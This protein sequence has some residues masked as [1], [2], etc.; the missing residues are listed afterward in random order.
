MKPIQFLPASAARGVRWVL[1]DVDDTLT[2][3]GVL[4]PEA[5]AALARL[6]AAGIPIV[7]VTG[8]SAGWAE[9]HLGEWPIEAAIAENGAVAYRRPR[10]GVARETLVDPTVRPNTDPALRR[11]FTRALA[12]VPR[13]REAEDNRLRLYDLAV[14]HAERVDPPLSAEEVSRVIACFEE[15]GCRAQASSIHVNAWSGDFDKRRAAVRVL[16]EWWGYDDSRDREAVLYVGDAL[17]DEGMFGH[18]PNAAAVANVDRWLDRLAH[19]PS[20]VSSARNGL[21]F[22]EIVGVFLSKREVAT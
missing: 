20:W 14:D 11:A 9:A 1:T 13:A 16:A 8:R 10:L 12:A 7:V 3:G 15:E 17:N 21:G 6:A 2:S 4:A 18:F 5:Y 19:R 22:A